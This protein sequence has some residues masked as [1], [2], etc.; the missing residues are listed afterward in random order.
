MRKLLAFAAAL[1]AFVQIYAATPEQEKTNREIFDRVYAAVKDKADLPT[2]QLALEIGKQ[3]LGTEYVG[4][5]LEVEPESLQIFLDKTDCILFVEMIS[6]FAL[7]V[8]GEKIV[9]AGNGKKFCVRETPSVRKAD[10]SYELLCYNIQNMRYRL[11]KVN[12][13]GSRL[14]YTSEWIFQN[15]TN[16]I[17]R[18]FSKDLGK[19][20]NQSFYY[21]T[22]HKDI[23]KQL[24]GDDKQT[25]IV[26]QAET[27]LNTMVPYYYISQES[28]RK[29]EIIS[30][31]QDGDIITFVDTLPGLDLAHVAMA[32]K[33]DDGKMHFIH[34]SSVK[35]KVV[36][37]EKTLADYARNGIRIS[38][39]R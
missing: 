8:K 22:T 18:E 3:F 25:A 30:Q 4:F 34:A 23:Y 35:K 26:K 10:P 31:I 29:P 37:E 1:L 20:F 28:L 17:L 32:C 6:A 13:Y 24:K 2:G 14:H 36:F 11:G 15:E 33:G 12:G 9:Q 21:M 5:T 38:R 27:L 16:G 7:T 19:P 39:L